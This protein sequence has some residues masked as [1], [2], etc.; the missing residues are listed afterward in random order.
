MGLP[1][2]RAASVVTVCVVTQRNI[3]RNSRLG[4]V[5]KAVFGSVAVSV[6]RP[7]GIGRVYH[8]SGLFT[9]DRHPD[10]AAIRTH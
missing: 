7:I 8:Y 2:I 4:M 5:V 10:R 3:R 9:T 6:V 1:Q